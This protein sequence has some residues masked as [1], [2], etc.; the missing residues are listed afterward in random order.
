MNLQAPSLVSST[1]D[2]SRFSALE[3]LLRQSETYSQFLAEQMRDYEKQLAEEA[4][5]LAAKR[6]AAEEAA[7]MKAQPE[8]DSKQ[9]GKGGKRK[10]ADNDTIE[11]KKAKITLTPTQVGFSQLLYRVLDCS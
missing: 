2:K 7:Q 11:A 8:T 6:I 5:E 3:H 10:R 4:R 1:L 9:K